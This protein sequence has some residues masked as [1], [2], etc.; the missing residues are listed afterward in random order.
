MKKRTRIHNFS[1]ISF[2]KQETQNQVLMLLLQVHFHKN[3]RSMKVKLSQINVSPVSAQKF[4]TREIGDLVESMEFTDIPP[5]LPRR[6]KSADLMNEIQRLY[7]NYTKAQEDTNDL[8]DTTSNK[9]YP[10]NSKQLEAWYW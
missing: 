3:V 9:N 2:L 6:K 10:D 5:D 8:P 4:T 1:F 7:Q